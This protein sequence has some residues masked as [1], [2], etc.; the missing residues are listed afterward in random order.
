[1]TELKHINKWIKLNVNIKSVKIIKK[2]HRMKLLG[3]SLNNILNAMDLINLKGRWSFRNGLDV[4]INYSAVWLL[5]IS[6]IW[7]E[8]II[9]R[10]HVCQSQVLCPLNVSYFGQIF[11]V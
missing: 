2:W 3:V 7:S 11:S 5:I 10:F 4:E 8:F 9:P 1:M 6:I